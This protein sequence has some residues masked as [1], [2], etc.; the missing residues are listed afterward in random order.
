MTEMLAAKV[1][2]AET[3]APVAT[4]ST[5]FV[6]PV[7][8]VV[9]TV[10]DEVQQTTHV[11]SSIFQP[12]INKLPSLVFALIFLL[13]GLFVIRQIMRILKRASK[14]SNMDGI[15][16]SFL[17]SIIKIVLYML[18]IVITLSILDV[19]MDSIVAV[20]ASA[21]VAVGLALKDSLSNLAGGFIILFSKPLKEGDTVEV[22]GVTGKVESI[23]ILYT[24]M[25]TPDNITV[26]IP[27]GVVSGGKIINYTQKEIRRVDLFFG[28]AYENDIDQA[29]KILMDVVKKAPEALEQPAPEVFVS[30]HDDSAVTLRLQVWGKNDQYWPLHYRLLEDVKKAFDENGISIPYPQMDVHLGETDEK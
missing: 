8:N 10:S 3:S 7:Q 13:F 24:R 28:I 15:M 14:H 11:L 20:I 19:P 22:D 27:N 6:Q 25:V 23:S 29:R 16:A 30:S 12:M 2:E 17:R 21:G 4:G 1:T 5:D 26:Y 9:D 18:L